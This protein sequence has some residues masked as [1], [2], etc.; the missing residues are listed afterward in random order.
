[1]RNVIPFPLR[2]ELPPDPLAGCLLWVDRRGREVPGRKTRAAWTTAILAGI[3]Y[4]IACLIEPAALWLL[5]TAIAL[6]A[7]IYGR[8]RW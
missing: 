3:A 5:P 6:A 8:W 4:I 2:R 7:A 1:M